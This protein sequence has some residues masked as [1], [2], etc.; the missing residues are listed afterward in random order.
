M[1]YYNLYGMKIKVFPK[2][3]ENEAI[4]VNEDAI[5]DELA[6]GYPL[7]EAIKRTEK[8]HGKIRI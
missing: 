1:K 8:F 5:K 7:P 2:A 4:V 3:S 6:K